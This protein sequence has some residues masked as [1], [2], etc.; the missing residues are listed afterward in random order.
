M[1]EPVIT[2]CGITYDRKD[3]EEHLQVG[4]GEGGR[5]GNFFFFHL[6]VAACRPRLSET[7]WR[8]NNLGVPYYRV[9]K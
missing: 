2:P 8:V 5:G 7:E 3:I 6:L 9:Q 1:Q 4:S